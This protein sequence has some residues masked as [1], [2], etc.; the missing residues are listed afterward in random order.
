M[1]KMTVQQMDIA[2]EKGEK[3]VLLDNLVLNTGG[4]ERQ[5]PGG[6]FTII[7]NFGR[8]ISKFYYG[9]FALVQKQ[10]AYGVY[11]HSEASRQI[12]KQMIVGY[13]EGQEHLVDV[14][15]TV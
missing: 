3:L 5:H 10:G 8:D 6:K 15:S 13:I 11:T 7:K 12:V 9:G 1:K 14:T 4:Y 2:V